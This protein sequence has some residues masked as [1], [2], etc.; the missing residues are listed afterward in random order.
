VPDWRAPPSGA[1]AGARGPATGATDRAAPGRADAIA[2]SDVA[3]PRTPGAPDVPIARTT[4][5]ADSGAAPG[6]DPG[7]GTADLPP[8]DD[9]PAAVRTVAPTSVAP[10]AATGRPALPWPDSSAGPRTVIDPDDLKTAF[11]ISDSAFGPL[12]PADDERS[13]RSGGATAPAMPAATPTAGRML[14]PPTLAQGGASQTPSRSLSPPTV[15]RREVDPLAGFQTDPLPSDEAVTDARAVGREPLRDVT[16]AP[17]PGEPA[18]D[19]F[20]P[21]RGRSRSLGLALSPVA[22]VAAGVLTILLAGQALVGWRDAIA[23]RLPLLSPLLSAIAAPLG[24]QV[25]PPREIGALTIESFELQAA[26][27]PNLLQLTALLRNRGGHSVAF[28]AMELT[29]TDSSGAVLVRKV[30]GP[31]V[32][33]SDPAAAS[34]G[35]GEQSEWPIRL[36]LEHRGLQPTGY[37]V[38]LYYP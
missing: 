34:R 11:F 27:S 1:Q 13:D 7:P 25:G 22:W 8:L 33:L 24:L 31:E 35:L 29:L 26:P 5:S 3:T 10:R 38:A 28:P 15:L 37:S 12:P 16:L 32:Y 18:I 17:D 23:A 2:G 4:A 9:W 14:Q 21:P 20:A 30:I 19:Y 36:A 6:A